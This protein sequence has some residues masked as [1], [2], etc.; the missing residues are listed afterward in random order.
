MLYPKKIISRIRRIYDNFENASNVLS[1]SIL[2]TIHYLQYLLSR[3][4]ISLNSF[5]GDWRKIKKYKQNDYVSIFGNGPSLKNESF[6]GAQRTDIITCNFFSRHQ[7]SVDLKSTFHIA[8]DGYEPGSSME[9]ILSQNSNA[10]LLHYSN[11]GYLKQPHKVIFHF[12]PSVLTVARWRSHKLICSYPLP[13]PLNSVQLALML[14]ILLRYKKIYLYGVDEDQ[15]TNRSHQENAHFYKEN[16]LSAQGRMGVITSTYEERIK[17]KHLVMVAY[18]NLRAIA[19]N[20][21]IEVINKNA[22]SFVDTFP[23]E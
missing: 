2:F 6:K 5:Q 11:R 7:N 13:A 12:V 10:Y 22:N 23:F 15:L 20:Y 17:S 3:F 18:R 4:I 21:G 14:A 8:A 19:D 16:I 1:F 9:E